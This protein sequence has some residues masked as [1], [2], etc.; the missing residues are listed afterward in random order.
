MIRISPKESIIS[1]ATPGDSIY[2]HTHSFET[3]IITYG[4]EEI[5]TFDCALI[6]PSC[7]D[8]VLKDVHGDDYKPK[9]EPF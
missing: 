4:Y 7:R 9:P 8:I 3:R 5:D 2:K 1:I 6:S